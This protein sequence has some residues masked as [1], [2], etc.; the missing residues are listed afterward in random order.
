MLYHGSTKAYLCFPLFS[1]LLH[2]WRFAVTPLC[3]FME[4]L[5]TTVIAE[6]FNTLS[7]CLNCSVNCYTTLNTKHNRS[8]TVTNQSWERTLSQVDFPYFHIVARRDTFHALLYG[9]PEGTLMRSTLL[10]HFGS[11]NCAKCSC[12]IITQ[13][14]LIGVYYVSY[15]ETIGTLIW[16]HDG[17]KHWCP[18]IPSSSVKLL[19]LSQ[20]CSHYCCCCCL[21]QLLSAAAWFCL[22][23]SLATCCSC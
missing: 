14:A 1:P 2:R 13:L 23:F 8:F 11:G 6:V 17:D 5:V 20:P 18:I 16:W 12:A 10:L 7:F 4:D 19:M 22:L 15:L 9:G 21:L 3:G